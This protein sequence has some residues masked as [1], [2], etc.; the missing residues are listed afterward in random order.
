MAKENEMDT[1]DNTRQEE[2]VNIA[3]PDENYEMEY[4][5][6]TPQSRGHVTNMELQQD[7]ANAEIPFKNMEERKVFGN[8][9]NTTKMMLTLFSNGIPCR[10]MLLKTDLQ[11]IPEIQE[12]K[13][14]IMIAFCKVISIIPTRKT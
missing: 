13:S 2:Q 10:S 14:E 3:T 4:D 6:I 7:L 8:L 9:E 5:E 11:A 12:R 1:N